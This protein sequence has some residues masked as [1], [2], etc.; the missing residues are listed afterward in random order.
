MQKRIIKFG[1]L[2]YPGGKFTQARGG[3]GLH[4]ASPWGPGNY[5][6]RQEED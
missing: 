4:R 2:V 3:G 5:W 1:T 6:N